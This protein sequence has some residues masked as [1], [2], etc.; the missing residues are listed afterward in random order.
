MKLGIK[1]ANHPLWE[2]VSSVT[3]CWFCKPRLQLGLSAEKPTQS[4]RHTRRSGPQ[5]AESF[6]YSTG[7]LATALSS[8]NLALLRAAFRFLFLQEP[9]LRRE[10][11][12]LYTRAIECTTESLHKNWLTS[13]LLLLYDAKLQCSISSFITLTVFSIEKKNINK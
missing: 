11:Q 12:V 3:P 5:R 13:M 10:K 1:R 8:L 4:V 2:P 9:K 7:L 6:Q